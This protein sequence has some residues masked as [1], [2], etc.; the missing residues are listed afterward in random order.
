MDDEGAYVAEN[1]VRALWRAT[2][3]KRARQLV[4]ADHEQVCAQLGVLGGGFGDALTRA[5]GL[6]G[7]LFGQHPDLGW[8]LD[9]TL[10]DAAAVA[11]A[12]TEFVGQARQ[13]LRMEVLEL[14]RTSPGRGN[15]A[16]TAAP[17]M[18]V[19]LP[20][21]TAAIEAV[22]P[23]SAAGAG[24]D[25][26]D[27]LALTRIVER[28]M[29]SYE[30]LRDICRAERT[31]VGGAYEA[32]RRKGTGRERVQEPLLEAAYRWQQASKDA[33]RA[34]TVLDRQYLNHGDP[35]AAARQA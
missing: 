20:R 19:L 11:G 35:T 24:Q 34:V 18:N 25:S 27:L 32:A 26:S 23:L 15:S 5:R 31:L 6:A 16:A 21:L 13:A 22:T 9:S 10:S 1:A 7:E 4:I 14:E 29:G 2:R 8:R 12:G 3:T 30:L 33:S 17:R 28:L